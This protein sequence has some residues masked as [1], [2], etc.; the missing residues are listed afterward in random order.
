MVR[1]HHSEQPKQHGSNVN[2][3]WIEWSLTGVIGRGSYAVNSTGIRSNTSI[4]GINPKP[5]S[6]SKVSG[7][8]R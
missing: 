8:F 2:A 3:E 5:P 7:V 1:V 6:A 4:K